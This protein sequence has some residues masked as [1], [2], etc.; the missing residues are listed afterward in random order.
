MEFVTRFVF[1]QPPFYQG[2][3]RCPGPAQALRAA[4]ARR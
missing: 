2:L 1:R 4:G 3:L